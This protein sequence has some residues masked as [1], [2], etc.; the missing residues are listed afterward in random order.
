MNE[1][2]VKLKELKEL[3]SKEDEQSEARRMEIALWIRENKTEEVER[4][5]V[6]S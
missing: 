5:F 4:L 1:V 3:M 2:D 6:R